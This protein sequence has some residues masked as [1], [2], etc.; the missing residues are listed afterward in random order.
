[1]GSA[2]SKIEAAVQSGA[3]EVK[4][5][6]VESRS[7]FTMNI[8]LEKTRKAGQTA[9]SPNGSEFGCTASEM[10]SFVN[11]NKKGEHL[12]RMATHA[13]DKSMTA[14]YNKSYIAE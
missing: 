2:D 5:A 3:D 8:A 6:S 4:I 12:S 14:Y 1:M 10:C 13:L 7:R 9:R 11:L